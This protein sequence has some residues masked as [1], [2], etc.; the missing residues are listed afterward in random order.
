MLFPL[1]LARH[2]YTLTLAQEHVKVMVNQVA[3]RM[4]APFT[5]TG[6]PRHYA[7]HRYDAIIDLMLSEPMLKQKELAARLGKSSVW[8]SY[9]MQ[10]DSFKLVYDERRQ[11]KNEM[12]SLAI[13]NKLEKVALKSLDYLV[14]KLENNPA[15]L[16]VEQVT[17][18]ADSTL[19]RLGYGV[20]LPGS[21]PPAVVFNNFQVTA[22][23]V[24][25]ARL[26]IQER[27]LRLAEAK[28]PQIDL[29][30][31]VRSPMRTAP[32]HALPTTPESIVG[33]THAKKPVPI[34]EEM[35]S[36]GDEFDLDT[37]VKMGNT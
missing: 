18:L 19:K 16:K 12:V 28:K 31:T 21:A 15:S 27:N 37:P 35:D 17:A 24:T 26:R 9:I 6:R 4:N 33:P 10:S 14:D 34:V 20:E 2:Y 36:G 30:A 25:A 29:T 32:N 1:L 13:A 23:D 3:T 22:E 11:L 5:P 7:V 8:L